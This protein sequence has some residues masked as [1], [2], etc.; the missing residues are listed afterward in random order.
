MTDRALIAE[1][2]K[3]AARNKKNR[4]EVQRVLADIPG[5][6][7]IIRRII[8]TEDFTPTPYRTFEVVDGISGKHRIVSC[9]AFFPDQVLHW[10]VILASMHIFKKGM[11]EYVCGSIP[12]RGVHYGRRAVKKW[13]ET[14]H[15][16]TKYCAK[17]DITKF[18]PSIDHDALKAALRRKIKDRKILWLYDAIIDSTDHGLPIGNYTSQWLANFLLQDLDH[19]IKEVFGVKYY[20]RYMDDMVLFGRNKKKLH[21]VVELIREELKPLGLTLKGN[22]QIFR[23]DYID[24]GGKRRGR[25]VDFMGFR[26]FRDRIE[27]RKRIALRL[28]R[29]IFKIKKSGRVTFRRA[30]AVI[31]YC[32]WLKY[33]DSA[34]FF[35]KYITP[36]IDFSKLKGVIRNENR[37]RNHPATLCPRTA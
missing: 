19:K 30:A 25:D 8:E 29:L 24:R 15:K 6:V 32:G 12:K 35:A 37:K 21:A 2:I 3:N 26:F 17:L 16:N 31:S 18:Y 34:G 22:W 27:M 36:N 4:A 7:E 23:V 13:I 28:R 33:T 11:Y 1:A 5:H 20:M 14:D 9:P 10:L